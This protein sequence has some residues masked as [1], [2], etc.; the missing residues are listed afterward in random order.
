M[1]KNYKSI[2]S[3]KVKSYDDYDYNRGLEYRNKEQDD[4]RRV[5]TPTER[6]VK[7]SR[8]DAA[9]NARQTPRN[10]NNLYQEK[11][12]GNGTY[13]EKA[14]SDYE[15]GKEV[16]NN[17]FAQKARKDY[18]GVRN[19]KAAENRQKEEEIKRKAAEAEEK[20][21]RSEN[22]RHNHEL[23]MQEFFRSPGVKR[24]LNE[25]SEY[26]S[27]KDYINEKMRLAARERDEKNRKWRE[28]TKR[29]ENQYDK[30]GRR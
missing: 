8:A 23:A 4:Y 17:A 12:K 29:T 13:A 25:V 16:L 22:R 15:R 10:A 5:R 20:R 27:P 30:A 14:Q 19:K 28:K 26:G 7:Q 3:R 6:K 2:N 9:I 11:P 18:E 24:A 1:A 21:I